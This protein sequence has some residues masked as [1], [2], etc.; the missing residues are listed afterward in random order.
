M[1]NGEGG[2]RQKWITNIVNIINIIFA[3]VDK[4]WGG[5]PYP[6]FVDKMV[7]RDPSLSSP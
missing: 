1:D 6:L 5:N 3:M 4:V 7:F 2:G